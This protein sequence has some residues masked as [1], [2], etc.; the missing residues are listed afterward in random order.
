MKERSGFSL[1]RTDEAM[2]EL[3]RKTD[4]TTLAV[5]AVDCV[6]RVLPYF[7]IQYPLDHRPGDAIEALL[8]W[9]HTGIF[10]MAEIR[11][12]ALD[13]HAA[14]REVGKENAASSAAHA[15]GQAASTAHTATHA[16]AAA[17]YAQQAVFLATNPSEAEDAVARE[18]DWQYRH[19]CDLRESRESREIP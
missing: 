15:A 1:A 19:L 5:W 2:E 9:I 14:A 6:A 3:V 8:T 4:H 18:R 17:A 10:S 12:A 11:K 7:E 16:L 13:A